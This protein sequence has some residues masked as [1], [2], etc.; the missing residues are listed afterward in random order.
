[1]AAAAGA[2]KRTKA[3]ELGPLPQWDLA[4]LYPARDD[5]GL[6]RDIATCAAAAASF[7]ARYEGKLAGLTGAELGG[8]IAAYEKMEE[9]LGR[10]LSYASLVHAGDMSG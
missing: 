6:E 4:D 2:R 7:R 8:A 10:V 5:A 1:M 9:T 3:P